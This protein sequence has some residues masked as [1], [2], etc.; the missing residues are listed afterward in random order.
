MSRKLLVAALAVAATIVVL[1]GVACAVDRA[2]GVTQGR[3]APETAVVVHTTGGTMRTNAGDFGVTVDEAASRRALAQARSSTPT[4]W[5][6][7]LV[8]RR[9]APL[10]VRI[11]A[12]KATAV[13]RAEDPTKRVEPIEP[14]IR[15]SRDGVAVKRGTPGRGLAAAAVIAAVRDAARH[16]DRTIDAEVTPSPLAP[17]HTVADAEALARRARS[18]TAEPLR[19][20][21]G[22]TD[23][24]ISSATLRSWVR[25]DEELHLALDPKEVLADLATALKAATTATQDATVRIEG[26]APVVIPAKAGLRCCAEGAPALVLDAL[27]DRSSGALVLPLRSNEPAR[28]TEEA[29][30]LEIVEA[31]ATFTTRH[32]AG[33]PR[34]TNIHRI[35]ELVDGAIIEPGKRFSIND[36]VGERT[37]E[38]GFIT[39]GSIADGSFTETVGGG[40]SQFATTL[41]NAAFFGGLDVPVYQSHSIYINRYPYGREATLS[42]PKPDLVISNTTPY[43]VLIDTSFTGTSVTVTLWSTRYAT[44]EQ[45]AQTQSPSGMC[46]RVKTERTRHYVDGRTKVDNVYATYRPAEGV[47]C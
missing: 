12:S 17:R 24:S 43:G 45:S 38:K 30:S 36:L 32:P 34:V 11:D 33:Q 4:A 41:F 8:A 13:V 16:G 26:G 40:I 47:Q 29:R 9:T 5:L 20:R 10:I 37:T 15:G 7:G 35:A 6:H 25:S 19:V 42:Y 1:L 22:D 31:I 27:L 39:G 3:I 28:T 44:G 46:T 14:S 23:A 2:R 21:A 18:L